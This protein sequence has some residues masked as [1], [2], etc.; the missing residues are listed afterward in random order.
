MPLIDHGKVLYRYLQGKSSLLLHSVIA[1]F[2]LRYITGSVGFAFFGIVMS[3]LYLVLNPIVVHQILRGWLWVVLGMTAIT[4]IALWNGDL[5]AWRPAYYSA[6]GWCTLLIAHEYACGRASALN[7]SRLLLFGFLG[8][9]TLMAPFKGVS[10]EAFNHYFPSSSRNGVSG[11]LIFFQIFYSAAYFWKER[12]APAI[13]PMLTFAICVALFGRSGI[14]VSAAIV[15][16]TVLQNVRTAPVKS[17]ASALVTGAVL[18][19][20]VFFPLLPA[21][22]AEVPRGDSGI[23]SNGL[24]DRVDDPALSEFR[25]GLYSIRNVMMAEYLARLSPQTILL[26]V[27]LHTVPWIAEYGGNAHNSYL[28]GHAFY[29]VVYLVFMLAVAVAATAGA[30]RHRQPFPLALMACFAGRAYFDS[31]ALFDV[32]DIGFFYCFFVLTRMHECRLKVPES[33]AA[34]SMDR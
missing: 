20:V 25:L 28:R 6:L 29:G 32:F 33:G 9:L 4:A 30:M 21:D 1:V 14:I 18:V 24:G 26:G 31:F 19:I 15:A 10:P 8:I 16:A 12:R 23:I 13:T 17:I 7:G 11:A 5:Y 2:A 34:A 27:P 22:L 3:V